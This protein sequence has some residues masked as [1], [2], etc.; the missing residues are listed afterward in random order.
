M[1]LLRDLFGLS[2]KEIW[3]ELSSRIGA[4]FQDGGFLGRDKVVARIRG[5]TITLDTYAVSTGK[6]TVTYTRIRAPYVSKDGFR[7]KIYRA[8]F[9]SRIGKLLGMQDITVGFTEFE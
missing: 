1:G 2:K 5:W 9:F 7:F 8:G 4:E 6:S 3:K